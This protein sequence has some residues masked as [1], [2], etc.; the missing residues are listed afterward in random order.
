MSQCPD[1]QLKRAISDGIQNGVDIGSTGP[2]SGGVY[3]N[4][5]S[6]YEHADKIDVTVSENLHLGRLVGPWT[7]PPV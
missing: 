2:D 5:P 1:Q 3:K 6:A 4:W 7:S